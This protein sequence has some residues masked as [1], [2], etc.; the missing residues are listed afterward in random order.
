[1]RNAIAIFVVGALAVAAERADA[2]ILTF[3]DFNIPANSNYPTDFQGPI[4]FTELGYQFSDNIVVYNPTGIANGP[5]YSGSN[6]AFNDYAG[7]GFGPQFTITKVGGGTFSFVDAYL[8]SWTHSS[9]NPAVPGS[10]QIQ[11]TILGYLDNQIVGVVSYANITTWTDV[12]AS[13][14]FGSFANIDT[15]VIDPTTTANSPNVLTLV[16]NLQLNSAV[17]AVPEPS[18]WAMAL[19]GFGGLGLLACRR[20]N[21]LAGGAAAL[22]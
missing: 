21:L 12:L 11:G 22:A 10:G 15:L 18:T 13:S 9:A 7:N 16:D 1:M 6:A 20:K 14:G 19:L 4:G 3:D 17:S 5:A 8:Q 2:A